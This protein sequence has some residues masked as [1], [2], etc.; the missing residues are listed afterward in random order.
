MSM[1]KGS[2]S[3][4]VKAI[5]TSIFFARGDHDIGIPPAEIE[6]YYSNALNTKLVILKNTGHNHFAF[7][8][9]SFLC[10]SLDYWASNLA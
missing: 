3:E 7:D 4:E 8:S 1:V 5:D 2:F 6:K 9:I 10:E